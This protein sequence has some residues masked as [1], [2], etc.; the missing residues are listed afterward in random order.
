MP[1]GEIPPMGLE[2]S[3]RDELY[4]QIKTLGIWDDHPWEKDSKRR[5]ARAIEKAQLNQ[6]RN[7]PDPHFQEQYQFRIYKTVIDR[8]ELREAIMI[9]LEERLSN[10]LI[11]EVKGLLD[12][13]I[14]TERLE[15]IGLEYKW[16]CLYLT[17]KTTFGEMR[18]RLFTGICRFAKRQE[19]FL[20]YLEKNNHQII[21]IKDKDFFVEDA[22]EWLGR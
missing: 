20:R 1:R 18:D 15:S 22:K 6:K 5:M 14:P 19:T 3:S 11:K 17:D 4:Q 13:N 7:K 9:R 2:K 16:L 12:Q 8:E 21:P 10:G